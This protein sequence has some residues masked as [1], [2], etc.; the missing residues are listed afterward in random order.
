MK[1]ACEDAIVRGYSEPST[2]ITLIGIWI[3]CPGLNP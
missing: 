1:N 3:V 2:E